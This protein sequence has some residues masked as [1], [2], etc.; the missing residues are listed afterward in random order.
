MTILLLTRIEA[1]KEIL[2]PI[3][4]IT[5]QEKQNPNNKTNKQIKTNNPRLQF[6]S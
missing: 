2:N 3:R 4:K 5:W 6:G 1:E